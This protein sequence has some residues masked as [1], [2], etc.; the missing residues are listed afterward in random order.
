MASTTG[1]NERDPQRRVTQN[2]KA[3]EASAEPGGAGAGGRGS[4]LGEQV[5]LSLFPRSEKYTGGGNIASSGSFY[6][7]EEA[8]EIYAAEAAAAAAARE[9]SNWARRRQEALMCAGSMEVP[10]GSSSSAAGSGAPESSPALLLRLGSSSDG[11]ES[12]SYGG[13]RA[14]GDGK[15]GRKSP[16]RGG[17]KVR[18][19]LLLAVAVVVCCLDILQISTRSSSIYPGMELM[20]THEP[21]RV[22]PRSNGS[23]NMRG[24]EDVAYM[25][26]VEQQALSTRSKVSNPEGFISKSLQ[27]SRTTLRHR[28]AGSHIR[29]KLPALFDPYRCPRGGRPPRRVRQS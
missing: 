12:L 14:E 24:I 9:A 13:R 7:D 29:S 25:D 21:S 15:G 8:E 11:G 10:V 1:G 22:E 18:S 27:I 26:L 6:D 28:R 19:S 3:G 23:P 20:R 5:C 16:P 2:W 4:A 17:G